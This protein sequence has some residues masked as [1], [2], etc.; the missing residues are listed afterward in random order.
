MCRM[1][2]YYHEDTYSIDSTRGLS[3]NPKGQSSTDSLRIH[4]VKKGVIRGGSF[5]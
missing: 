4:A 3:V 1:S 2:D 5:W